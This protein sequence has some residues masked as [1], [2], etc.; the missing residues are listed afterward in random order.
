MMRAGQGRYETTLVSLINIPSG[1]DV[2]FI[3]LVISKHDFVNSFI[4]NFSTLISE[5]P[6]IRRTSS[7]VSV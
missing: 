7:F 6:P 2:L 5:K 3:S 4:L 1:D